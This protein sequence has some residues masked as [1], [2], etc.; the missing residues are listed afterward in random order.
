MAE[1]QPSPANDQDF[2]DEVF[3]RIVA[4][5]EEGRP[6]DCAE[7]AADHAHL[8]GQVEEL[9]WLAQQVAV[10]ASH[11]LPA[12]PGYTL[13]GELGRGGMGTVF[14]AQQ[15]RLGDRPVAL[16]LLPTSVAQS[17][18]ARKRFRIEARA[19]AR[20]RHP[21]VVS[22]HDVVDEGGVYAYA[23]EWVE[24]RSLADLLE[25]LRQEYGRKNGRSD[26]HESDQRSSSPRQP[27]IPD[28]RAFLDASETDLREHASYVVYICRLGVALARALAAVHREGLLHRDVKPS[29]ILLRRDGTPLL[30]DFGLARDTASTQV[31]EPGQFVGTLAYAAPEQLRG[32]Q[33]KLDGRTDVYG[34][35]VTLYHALTLELPFLG[36][37]TSALLREIERGQVVSLRRTNSGAPHDL[38]TIISKAIDADPARRYADA[39]ALAFD[40]NAVL[41]GEPI[42]AKPPSLTYVLGKRIRRHGSS[43]LLGAMLLALLLTVGVRTALGWWSSYQQQ[44]RIEQRGQGVQSVDIAILGDNVPATLPEREFLQINL[45]RGL[46]DET[47]FA[48]SL[49]IGHDRGRH[50]GSVVVSNDQCLEVYGDLKIGCSADGRLAVQ[51]GGKVKCASA[52]LGS[53][54]GARGEARIVESGATWTIADALDVGDG[55]PGNLTLGPHARVSAQNLRVGLGAPGR[56]AVRGEDTVLGV[57]NLV[58]GQRHHGRLEIHDNALASSSHGVLGAERGARGELDVSGGGASLAVRGDLDVGCNGIGVISVADGGTLQAHN[59]QLGLKR[60]GTGT[61]TVNDDSSMVRTTRTIFVGREGNAKLEINNAK[62]FVRS[63]VLL[64]DQPGIR[65]TAQLRGSNATCIVNA[66]LAVGRYGAG[67]LHIDDG[68]RVESVWATMAQEEGSSGIVVVADPGTVWRT[69]ATC[70]IGGKAEGAGGAAELRVENGATFVVE[71]EMLIWPHGVVRLRGGQIAAEVLTIHDGA[72]LAVEDG[73]VGARLVRG[74]LLIAGGVLTAACSPGNI[75]IHGDL[76]IDGG[77]LR[78]V[79]AGGAP[80]LVGHV[81][82]DGSA[83]LGGELEVWIQGDNPPGYDDR[84]VV[85]SANEVTGRFENAS[86]PLQ[87]ATGGTCELAHQ[88]GEIV[89]THFEPPAAGQ[90][91]AP[92]PPHACLLPVWETPTSGPFPGILREN[93]TAG[94]NRVFTG[95]PD[96]ISWGLADG[97]VVFDFDARRVID[98]PGPDFNVYEC[99]H[100]PGE[101]HQLHVAVST[102][103]STFVSVKHTEAPVVRVGGDEQFDNDENGRSYDLAP[104]GYSGIRYIRLRGSSSLGAGQQASGFDLDA[105]GAVN[106]EFVDGDTSD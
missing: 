68:A 60:D 93:T 73:V 57:N 86:S 96:D 20:L 84:F 103:G 97:Y 22:V 31:T 65:G 75:E 40:L 1:S 19:I 63:G 53:G 36:K 48:G 58:I 46:G 102:D 79:I 45:L 3:D 8:L 43:V 77:S 90:N 67:E 87:L 27:S 16:K 71:H 72:T 66:C 29:N 69:K 7:L 89:L 26:N 80:P 78:I 39:D 10:G 12:V 9:A 2:L 51:N 41:A 70:A 64:G 59:I 82:V 83:M 54:F 55:G 101:F 50:P 74:N 4:S 104:T 88:D 91:G 13:L 100:G 94:L 34:L 14:L 92:P 15:E 5:L 61:L 42:R 23:M 17:A 30:S 99:D 52:G 38:Q 95:P 32:E 47:V 33:E 62:C 76:A 35:G 25:H 81:R 56:V 18:A 106:W 37:S 49:G 85:L 44:F 24:G 21:N 105:V 98:G 28:V 6:V 11:S